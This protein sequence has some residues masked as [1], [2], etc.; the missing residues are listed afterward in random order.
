MKNRPLS[1]NPADPDLYGFLCL[2]GLMA[3]LGAIA[4]LAFAHHLD[5]RAV[6]DATIVPGVN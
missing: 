3:C 2:L 4:V 5:V 6:L 1:T